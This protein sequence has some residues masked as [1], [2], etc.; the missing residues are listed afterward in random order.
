MRGARHPALPL[1]AS[2]LAVAL[3]ATLAG[4]C[5]SS[6]TNAAGEGST[7]TAAPPGAVVPVCTAAP[8][9]VATLRVS[10]VDC[11]KG[12]EVVSAWIAKSACRAV[13]GAS[14]TSCTADTY[15][16]L[17]ATTELGLAVSC[18]R[19]GRSISFVSRRK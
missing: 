6:S 8:A 15:R 17:G 4:G 1:A 7:K 12:R 18:S 3:L 5:S 16:C 19:P 2:L 13:P 11:A 10:G 14:R 9:G